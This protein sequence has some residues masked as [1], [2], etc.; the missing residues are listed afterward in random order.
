[1]PFYALSQV[2]RYLCHATPGL[3]AINGRCPLVSEVFGNT[4]SIAVNHTKGEL[5]MPS[6]INA[7]I[8]TNTYVY[9]NVAD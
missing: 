4:G 8:H 9:S 2:A 7:F 1:M 5:G 6:T 3:N